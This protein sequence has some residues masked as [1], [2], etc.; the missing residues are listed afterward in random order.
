[1][2]RILLSLALLPVASAAHAA[3]IEGR[4]QNPKDSVIVEVA[5]C[6]RA[7]CGEV[8]WASAKAKA[9][10]RKGGTANLV[11]TRLMSGFTP[12]G[13]GGYKGKVLLPKRGIHATGTIR[14]T[15]NNTLL[16]KGCAIA[17]MICK[18]QRWTR[19]N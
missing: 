6:G 19:V 2:K 13:D 17:G 9:D 7:Y 8:A 1:M 16:V 4:W 5:R 12:D 3:P 11:G 14:R 10:A 15:G 18:E